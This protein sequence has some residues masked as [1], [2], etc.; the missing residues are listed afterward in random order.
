MPFLWG[1]WGVIFYSVPLLYRRYD[2]ILCW[3]RIQKDIKLG[4]KLT[5]VRVGGKGGLGDRKDV[6]LLTLQFKPL[7]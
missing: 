6:F 3:L 1:R 5:W 2:P 4:L 7:G